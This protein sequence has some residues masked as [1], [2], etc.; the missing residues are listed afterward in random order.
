MECARSVRAGRARTQLSF[1]CLHAHG[2]NHDRKRN[3][4]F[5]SPIRITMAR[6]RANRK[7]HGLA[8]VDIRGDRSHH[9]AGDAF[10]LVRVVSRP[11]QALRKQARR[12]GLDRGCVSGSFQRCQAGR[13]RDEARCG[14]DY[15]FC[16]RSACWRWARSR[17]GPNHAWKSVRPRCS[18][19]GH[20][21]A[22]RNSGAK[23]YWSLPLIGSLLGL[24]VIGLLQLLF[25]GTAYPF[26]TRT[27]LLKLAAYFLVLFLTAQAFRGRKDLQ[28]SR[29]S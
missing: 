21:L 13:R 20:L 5:K 1:P 12:N 9:R 29:G 24:L 15:V 26:L 2:R 22:Y 8:R 10:L 4:G 23:I 27:M 14:S 7:Y 11:Q 3:R 17:C 19:G 25:H 6:E 28:S 16:W 18:C